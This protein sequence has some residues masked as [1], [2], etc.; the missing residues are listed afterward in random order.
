MKRVI[1]ALLALTLVL[2]WAAPGS[3]AGL[4]LTIRDGRVSI[5]AQDVTLRQILTEWARV[6][7]TRIVNLERVASP[8]VTLKFDDVPEAE[9][10][11]ILLRALP[12]YWAAP[13]AVLMAD[14]SVYDRIGLMT[15]TTQVAAAPSPAPRPSAQQF[16]QDPNVTQLRSFPPPLSPGMVPEPSEGQRES[17]DAAVAAAAAAGL[18]APA[19]AMPGTISPPVGPLQP[20]ARSGGAAP[21]TL[22]SPQVAT[23]SNPWNAPIGAAR[24]GLAAPAPPPPSSRPAGVTSPQQADQ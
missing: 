5:D 12:G 24:P 18:T 3:A 23:P 22:T 13:R 6:G 8:P 19:Q 1:F 16:F 7:K 14:A 15:T 21:T 11:D 9:A 17:I 2:G 20:P 4:K 10:L